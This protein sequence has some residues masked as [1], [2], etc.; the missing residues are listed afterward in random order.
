[1]PSK[2]PVCTSEEVC[3]ALTRA[4]FWKVKQK[5]S[6]IK[7]SSGARIVIIPMHSKDLKCGT[8]KGILDQA[9]LSVDDFSKYL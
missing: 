7:M 5:G 8:L 6:H 3:K 2:Y 1:M 4:G 9:G